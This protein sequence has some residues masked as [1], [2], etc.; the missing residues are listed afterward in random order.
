MNTNSSSNQDAEHLNLLVVFHYV[1]AGI[2]GVFALFPIIHLVVGLVMLLSP[3]SFAGNGQKPP[4]F[5]GLLFVIMALFFIMMGLTL[6][7][8][9]FSAG[10]CLARRRHYTFCFVVAAVE[11]V[12]M[13]FGTVLGIFTILVLSRGSVKQLFIPVAAAPI[14]PVP[15]VR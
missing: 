4:A 2:A 6:A 12:F 5:I 8:F 3:E 9:V 11:C 10:R 13:P 1:V 15:P 7:V 14:S